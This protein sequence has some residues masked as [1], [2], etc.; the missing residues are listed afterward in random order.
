MK[1]VKLL[2]ISSC[3]VSL[4]IASTKDIFFWIPDSDKSIA[5]STPVAQDWNSSVDSEEKLPQEG[6]SILED[7]EEIFSVEDPYETLGL[8]KDFNKDMSEDEACCA[9][10]RIYLKK[11]LQYHGDKQKINVIKKAKDL[12]LKN[13]KSNDEVHEDIIKFL[14]ELDQQDLEQDLELERQGLEDEEMFDLKELQWQKEQALKK[15]NFEQLFKSF[16]VKAQ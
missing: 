1:C 9:V 16:L 2:L 11:I 8:R 7:S 15:H 5:E 13:L 10:H 12:I 6:I 4:M 3:F 14:K